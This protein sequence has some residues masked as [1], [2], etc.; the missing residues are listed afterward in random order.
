MIVSGTVKEGGK[1]TKEGRKLGVGTGYSRGLRG[2]WSGQEPIG[3]N[4]D[5][6]LHEHW[7]ACCQKT[8][9]RVHMHGRNLE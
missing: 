4:V 2:Q 5:D 8:L 1:A 3:R 6:V 9:V 7:L